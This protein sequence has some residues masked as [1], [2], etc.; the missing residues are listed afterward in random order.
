MRAA[1]NC[2]G[3]LLNDPLRLFLVE[4]TIHVCTM[5]AKT[6]HGCDKICPKS[7]QTRSG[8]PVHILAN[9]CTAPFGILWLGSQAPGPCPRVPTQRV[10]APRPR[11]E[12]S[13][14]CSG[15]FGGS[16]VPPKQNTNT[17]GFAPFALLSYHCD[18]FR[19]VCNIHLRTFDPASAGSLER[20]ASL[21]RRHTC[22]PPSEDK[23]PSL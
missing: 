6:S 14:Q 17:K 8:S 9:Q 22:R 16:P 21:R 7:Q 3:N 1:A 5:I 18:V 10:R 23:S 4:P 2:R 19:T 13:A 15:D 20:T 12:T 11:P